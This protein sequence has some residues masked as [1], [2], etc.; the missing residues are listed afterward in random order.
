M[1]PII[2]RKQTLP[3]KTAK[4]IIESLNYDGRG[5]AHT[6]GKVVFIDE[7]LP[8]EEV[9]FIYTNTYSNYAE[10]RVCALISKANERAEPKCPHFGC[11][12]GCSLQH[13]KDEAQIKFK[14]QLLKEQLSRIGKVKIS[15]LWEPLIGPYWNYRRK[16]RIGVKYVAKKGRVFVGFR[17]RRQ[18]FLADI[19]GCKVMHPTVGTKL[20]DLAKMIGQL[21]IKDKIPQIEVAIGD[22]DNILAFRVLSPPT[23]G[24]KEIIRT[25]SKIHGLNIYL[26]PQGPDSI[27]PIDNESKIGLTYVLPA[28]GI[29]FKFKPTM[30]TQVNYEI[31]QKMINRVMKA[32]ALNSQ[33][34][35]L[36]L[37][38]GLGNFT[39]PMATI[40]GN[41]AGVEV[42]KPLLNCAEENAIL[43]GLHNVKFYM[44]DLSKALDNVWE[45][46]KFNKLLLNP[47]RSGAAQVL[48]N[49]KSCNISQIIYIS[50]NPSTLARDAGILVNKLGYNLVKAGVIDMFPQ[51]SH[52][53]SIALFTKP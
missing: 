18:H 39:L 44:A 5:V 33:D 16:A 38:C 41:V 11:C 37:F 8:G 2:P 27:V 50:C 40:A 35:V 48:H 6:N 7:A 1:I 22:K 24:D 21:T 26:Q 45:K 28:Q 19:Q 20:L 13:V 43:N 51:T 4:V 46:Q 29:K 53:E 17:E 23:A 9:E 15:Q 32:F 36:D 14:E 12:G 47:P 52:V 30:F 31:N 25:F 49:F 3:E 10:G 42:N 34:K